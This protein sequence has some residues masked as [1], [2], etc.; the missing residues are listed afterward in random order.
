MEAAA[1]AGQVIVY[2]LLGALYIFLSVVTF[3]F[4][5]LVPKYLKRI[6]DALESKENN[7]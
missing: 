5:F 4:L 7:T 1:F 3:K 6:A 2:V